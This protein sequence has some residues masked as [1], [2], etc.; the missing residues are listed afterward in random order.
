MHF[1]N[2]QSK[3]KNKKNFKL[4]VSSNFSINIINEFLNKYPELA[5][6]RKNYISKEIEIAKN[7]CITKIYTHAKKIKAKSIQKIIFE[8]RKNKIIATTTLGF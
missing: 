4:K 5:S 7:I 1:I 8:K 2:N 3:I 6:G